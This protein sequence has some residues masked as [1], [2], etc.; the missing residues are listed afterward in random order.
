MRF[1]NCG[2][3]ENGNPCCNGEYVILPAFAEELNN[4]QVY[5]LDEARTLTFRDS[6]GRRLTPMLAPE[7]W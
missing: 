6:V 1:F 5:N 2:V 4:E 3:D 7:G